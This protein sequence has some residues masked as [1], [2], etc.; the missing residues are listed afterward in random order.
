MRSCLCDIKF[1]FLFLI[2]IPCHYLIFN[3][4]KGADV[5]HAE[6]HFN[7]L[8]NWRGKGNCKT[9]RP[10]LNVFMRHLNAALKD[11]TGDSP[12]LPLSKLILKA[13]TVDFDFYQVNFLMPSI[14]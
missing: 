9:S 7:W 10:S 6:F 8:S 11:I 14:L 4:N 13:N 12:K 2:K 5:V 1:V 3:S